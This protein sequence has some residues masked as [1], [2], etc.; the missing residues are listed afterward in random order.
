MNTADFRHG[1]LE[2]VSQDLAVIVFE[3]A[4]P[5]AGLNRELALEIFR[6]GGRILWLAQKPD[7]DL[8]T[9]VLP[10]VDEI[11]LPL[12]EILPL[13]ILSI[14]MAQRKGVEAGKFQYVQ[15]VTLRE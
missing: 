5:T 12:V 2:L 10:E 4:T 13:Q 6:L 3:G 15:K 7:R 11:A 8:P 14:L 9:L 1:P